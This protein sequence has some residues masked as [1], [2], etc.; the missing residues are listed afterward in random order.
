[1]YKERLEKQ[2]RNEGYK[3]PILDVKKAYYFEMVYMKGYLDALPEGDEKE[4]LKQF[5]T[6]IYMC[7]RSVTTLGI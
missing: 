1:M 3:L 7:G 4:F 5:L 2:L 6:M